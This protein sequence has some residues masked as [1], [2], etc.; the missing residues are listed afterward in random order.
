MLAIGLLPAC[1]IVL[2]LPD[3]GEIQSATDA[4]NCT[5]DEC[6][7]DWDGSEAFIDT[8]T[9]VPPEDSRFVEWREEPGYLCGGSTEPCS[10]FLPAHPVFASDVSVYL[11]PIFQVLNGDR[12]PEPAEPGPSDASFAK[13]WTPSPASQC[14]VSENVSPTL[15]PVSAA[16]GTIDFERRIYEPSIVFTD[17]TFTMLLRREWPEST[18]TLEEAVN[19]RA[20]FYAADGAD[21]VILYD[22]GTHGDVTAGDSVYTRSCL[23]VDLGV[24]GQP[25]AFEV[26]YDLFY[27]NPALRGTETVT[28]VSNAVRMNDAGIFVTL[29]DHYANAM[30]RGRHWEIF[31]PGSCVSCQQAWH[32]FGDIFD[33]F[34]LSPREAF[35]GQGF[36]RVHDFITGTGHEPP[37]PNNAYWEFGMGDGKPH[38]EYIGM[39][40]SGW[41]FGGSGISHELAHGLLG[42]NTRDFPAS[43]EGQWNAGDG[44]HIDGTS[45]LRGNL[46]GPIWDPE[47]GPPYK[48][49]LDDGSSENEWELPQAAFVANGNGGVDL[50][51]APDNILQW[52]DIFL[53][54]MGLM[55]A[56]EATERYYK[57]V[58]PVLQ[59]CRTTE[60]HY[61][62]SSTTVVA[63]ELVEFGVSDLIERY[64]PWGS[65]NPDFDPTR[66]NIG[67]LLA[68]DRLHTEA[69]ITLFSRANRELISTDED[70]AAA[71]DA[72]W[73]WSTGGRSRFVIDFRNYL[74]PA[75]Q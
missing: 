8:F 43:G 38:P 30:G 41:P 63:D 35:A 21:S 1:K 52:A 48:V 70:A 56:S 18:M 23:A 17:E 5:T 19:D 39:V 54:M 20:T 26:T 14:S 6:T 12:S 67:M 64:G 73:Y 65:N 2:Q 16:M 46:Q 47:R 9:P 15:A 22:D 3:G 62:C 7:I 28:Q 44:F 71:A 74:L 4:N 25:N 36:T 11:E 24:V 45:T 66:L 34:V 10:V 59:D 27:G 68:S 31:D 29:G 49:L 55:D 40:Y 60:L 53:Y 33:F 13:A 42:I 50:A 32:H 57:V 72:L 61:I 51:P 37:F 58:N 75:A 69:E